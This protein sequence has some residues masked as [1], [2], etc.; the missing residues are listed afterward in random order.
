MISVCM[1]TYNGE[2]YIREQMESILCQLNE[3]DEVIVSDDG[4]KDGTIRILE[5]FHDERIK[6]LQNEGKHGFVGNFENALRVAK[7]DFI[8]LSDQDDEWMPNKV[9]VVLKELK[10]SDLIVHDAELIDGEGKSM[11]KNYY[12]FLHNSSCFLMNL[13]KTRFLGCCMA[14]RKAVLDDCLP[15]PQNTVGHDYWIGMYSLVNYRVKFIPDI[16]LMYRRHGGNV[17]PS[18]E[19]SNNSMFYKLYTKRLQLLLSIAVKK[20]KKRAFH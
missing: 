17:S 4:S 13:W 15:F 14:F 12:S 20:I 10:D 19:K 18:S 1:A 2:K 7:G 8:F 11:G 16:L 6:I 3:C 9:A 5:S